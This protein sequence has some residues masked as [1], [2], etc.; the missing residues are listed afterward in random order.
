MFGDLLQDR[1]H[2]A[3]CVFWKGLALSLTSIT[4]NSM[5]MTC[6]ALFT[7]SFKLSCWALNRFL[8]T[9]NVM[10]G[11]S[12][13]AGFI[14]DIVDYGGVLLIPQLTIRV[15]E[16][17]QGRPWLTR[18]PVRGM[19]WGPPRSV[20]NGVTGGGGGGGG[21]RFRSSRGAGPGATA[22]VAPPKGRP[23][24]GFCCLAELTLTSYMTL[25]LFCS[26]LSSGA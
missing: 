3:V 11:C 13:S 26:C 23:W 19:E 1:K 14:A 17:G 15:D 5:H 16:W 9:V 21:V 20:C 22:P 4:T 7:K 25:L 12:C 6:H 2:G 18:G 24:V 10:S 8:D